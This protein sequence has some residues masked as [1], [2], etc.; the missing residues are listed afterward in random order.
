MLLWCVGNKRAFAARAANEWRASAVCKQRRR[1]TN[2]PASAAWCPTCG[3]AGRG[4]AGA[5]GAAGAALA[6]LEGA[7]HAQRPVAAVVVQ[8]RGAAAAAVGAQVAAALLAAPVVG[9]ALAPGQAGHR[10]AGVAPGAL[11]ALGDARPGGGSPA[12]VLLAGRL[13][14]LRHRVSPISPSQ[15]LGSGA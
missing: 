1:Q 12:V 5:G 3:G 7:Q 15:W 2:R 8:L 11:V 13:G 6:V 10:A 14:Q 9:L 4:S